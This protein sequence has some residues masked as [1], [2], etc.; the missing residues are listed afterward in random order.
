MNAYLCISYANGKLGAAF[1]DE[2]LCI[3]KILSD[4]AEDDTF[5]I[6]KSCKNLA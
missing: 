5:S 2:D 3:V 6:L 1:Y 4:V